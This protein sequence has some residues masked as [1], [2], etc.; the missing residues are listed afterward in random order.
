MAVKRFD[1]LEHKLSLDQKLK[2]LY[3]DRVKPHRPSELVQP[4]LYW[5]SPPFL[6]DDT[7]TWGCEHPLIPVEE[8]PKTRPVS[9]TTQVVRV[10]V[11]WFVR[12]STFDQM[13][14]IIV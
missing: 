8:L 12:F 14:R 7:S 13:V 3:T 9:L 6:Y 1:A 5:H 2:M 4:P 10:L 11:E